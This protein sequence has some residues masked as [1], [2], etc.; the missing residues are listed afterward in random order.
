MRARLLLA[1]LLLPLAACVQTNATLLN[2]SPVARATVDPATVRI[3]RTADQIGHRFEE[4]AILNSTGESS[5]TNEHNMLESMRR[6]AG[7]LGANA[8]ILDDIREA[9]AGAKV[10]GAFLGTGSERKGRS[11]AVFVFYPDSAA[12]A[13][14]NTT[15]GKAGR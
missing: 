13:A 7:A 6:K 14:R 1:A 8:I 10:A 5:W 12:A 11:V 4:L 2:P 9:S 15:G 3:Y